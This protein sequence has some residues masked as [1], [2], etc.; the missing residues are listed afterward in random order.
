MKTLARL[1][2]IALS[3]SWFSAT[4]SLC[5]EQ[6]AKPWFAVVEA[7]D[8]SLTG[9]WKIVKGQEGYFPAAPNCWSANRIRG[10][11][12]ATPANASAEIDVPADGKYALWVRYESSYGFD[13]HFTVAI[14]QGGKSAAPVYEQRFGDRSDEKCFNG[15]WRV[16]GPWSYHNTDYVY[17]KGIADLKK[18]R[19]TIELFKNSSHDYMAAR[20]IDLIYLTDDLAMAPG[21]ELNAWYE[22]GKNV[23]DFYQPP[24][25]MNCRR[26]VYFRIN[27][28]SAG[29]ATSRVILAYRH[30]NGWRGPHRDLAFTTN[31]VLV[32][33]YE[34]EN[35]EMEI[36]VERKKAEFPPDELLPAGFKSGWARYDLSTFN[37]ASIIVKSG[38][39]LRLWVSHHADGNNAVAFDIGTNNLP[40]VLVATGNSRIEDE[41]FRGKPAGTAEEFAKYFTDQ[42]RAYK[43]PGKRPFLFGNLVNPEPSFGEARWPFFEAAGGS[44]IYFSVPPELYLPENAKRWGANRSMAYKALQN[45]TLNFEYYEGDYPKMRKALE[46]VHSVLSSNSVGDIP[47]TFKMIE[48]SGPPA[49]SKMSASTI[50]SGKFRD[51]LKT[52]GVKPAEMLS[53]AALAAAVAAG[54]TSDADLWPSVNLCNGTPQDAAE[55]PALFYH[56]KMFGS[57]LFADNSAMAAKMVEEIFPPGSRANSGATYPQTGH[58]VRRNWYDEFM[59]FRRKGMTSFGSEITWGLCGTPDYAGTQSES[60]E[61]TI[62][63]GV[64][65]YHD[66]TLGPSHLLACK[67]YGY[68]AEYVELTVYALASH[69]FRSVHYYVNGDFTGL[70]HY[71]AMKKAGY[72]MGAIEEQLVGAKVVPARVALGW[73]E[74][75]AIWDQAVPTDSGYNRPGNIMYALERHYLYLL[76]RHLQLPVDL[77]TEADIEEGRLKDYDVY[78]LVG[79]HM[80]SKPAAALRNWVEA[81]GVLVSGAGGGLWDEYNRPLDTLKDVYGIKGARQYAREQGRE[82]IPGETYAVNVNDNHLEKAE[83]AL[84][85]KL[86]LLHA[87]PLDTITCGEFQLPVLGYRQSFAVDGGGVIG[88][89]QSGNA[90]IVTNSFGKGRAL[91][92]GF[93]PGISYFYQAY[94]FRPY[95]RGGEDLSMCLYPDYKPLVRDAMA[96]LLKTVWPAMGAAVTTSNPFVEANLMLQTNGAFYVALVNYSGKPIKDLS[97]RIRAADAGKAA[98]AKAVFGKASVKTDAEHLIVTTPIDRF[99]WLVLE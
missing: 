20:I 92:M 1:L 52:L 47:Q 61:G 45:M 90:A 77:V 50:I 99:E 68:P 65:K 7:E 26:P 96:S 5:L 27:V 29:P 9:D 49:L 60:Y 62:A 3:G 80:A 97:V 14:R 95:G 43:V 48:E 98:K 75:T 35:R 87:H 36:N 12:D 17:Q 16:Q 46:N 53:R 40:V 71:K 25:M 54:K 70:D 56:S 85:A 19:A 51:Y 41:L 73:S 88:A 86:E 57:I 93:L 33:R 66:A 74:T 94:P 69:G 79:D 2:L 39:K 8:M 13:A 72:A 84:R 28:D 31:S 11:S 37:T 4:S 59:L 18:G 64:A 15:A 83:Q 78:F 44:G 81:G 82:Y 63:R 42:L 30:G 21:R 91:I 32:E 10:G 24:V 38:V 6:G 76:L 67:I 23:A 34:F 89:L 58:G 22:R 55:N